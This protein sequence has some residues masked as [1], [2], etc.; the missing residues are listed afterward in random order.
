MSGT[1]ICLGG[2]VVALLGLGELHGQTMPYGSGM[3][4]SA[5]Y[6]QAMDPPTSLPTGS[7]TVPITPALGEPSSGT[8]PSSYMV[9]PKSPGCC[10]PLLDGPIT[11]ELFL[12]SGL[13]FNISG[14]ALGNALSTGWDIEGG[15]RT[16]FFNPQTDAAW[17][18]SG[19]ISNV[20][21][22]RS[23]TTVTVPHN[24]FTASTTA[25]VPPTESTSDVTIGSLNRTFANAGL[26]YEYYLV[27]NASQLCGCSWRI[28]GEFG[29]RFGT[30]K[31]DYVLLIHD[32]KDAYG[33]YG[34]I[35][36]D[37]EIPYNGVFLQAG[38]RMEYDA[39]WSDILQSQNNANVQDINLLFSVGVRF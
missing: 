10:G 17:F 12:R 22:T 18:V 27:G 2:L 6:G 11:W 35:F 23:S 36:S 1:K 26:G 19:S 32:T 33:L 24:F 4:G 29:G 34:A 37:V 25:G 16:L 5:P 7:V 30:D 9:Y 21:Y 38:I 39:I 15:G 31:L 14:G 13:S 8:Q 3:S 28:G 20:N